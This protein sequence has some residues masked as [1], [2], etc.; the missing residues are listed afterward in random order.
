MQ[1]VATL[2]II[3][4]MVR[5]LHLKWKQPVAYNLSH[6]STKV[7]MLVQFLNEV[8][9]ACQDVGLRVVA[10]CDMGNNNVKVMKLLG[11][12]R[13]QPFFQLQNKA[14]ATIYDPHYLLKVSA[15]IHSVFIRNKVTYSSE[16]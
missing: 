8:L 12:T 15:F 4:F 9:G 7:E 13:R 5:G 10:V 1:E 3:L 16:T 14:T 11:S 2:Q 6:G